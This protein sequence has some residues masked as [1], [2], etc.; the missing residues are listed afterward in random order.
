MLENERCYGCV[1]LH[2]SSSGK[3]YD[4][5]AKVFVWP[6]VRSS[7]IFVAVRYH[8]AG[9]A[10]HDVPQ[11]VL[12]YLQEMDSAV[13]EQLELVTAAYLTVGG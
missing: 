6:K 2:T 5:S 7:M 9:F 12:A 11:W 1:W 13:L 3:F 4:D 8:T 10:L